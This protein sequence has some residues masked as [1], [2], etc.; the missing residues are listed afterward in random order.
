MSWEEDCTD[1]IKPAL[2]RGHDTGVSLLG[3]YIRQKQVGC[4]YSRPET[5]REDITL[6]N[7]LTRLRGFAVN[8]RNHLIEFDPSVLGSRLIGGNSHDESNKTILTSARNRGIMDKRIAKGN[9]F[10]HIGFIVTG[11]EEIIGHV[12]IASEVWGRKKGFKKLIS[13]Q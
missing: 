4:F 12:G 5:L 11:K 9:G 7:Q 3:I 13:R 8:R 1:L 2:E 6:G 10:A